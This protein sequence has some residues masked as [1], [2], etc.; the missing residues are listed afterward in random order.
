MDRQAVARRMQ[1]QLRDLRKYF[2][3]TVSQQGP[4]VFKIKTS[5]KD[6]LAKRKTQKHWL[7]LKRL[8]SQASTYHPS[9]R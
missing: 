8:R 6:H 1:T 9:K 7:R 2:K 5:S 3:K 4:V